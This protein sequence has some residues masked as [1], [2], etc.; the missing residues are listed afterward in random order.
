M[1]IHPFKEFSFAERVKSPAKRTNV[2]LSGKRTIPFS[3]GDL[4]RR[5]PFAYRM[6]DCMYVLKEL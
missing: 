2:R 5:T 4:A 6:L 1:S 3:G